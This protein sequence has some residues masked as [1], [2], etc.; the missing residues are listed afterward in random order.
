L[1]ALPE[2]ASKT[3][4][5]VKQEVAA[6]KPDEPKKGFIGLYFIAVF[7]DQTIGFFAAVSTVFFTCSL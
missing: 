5:F 6:P 7:V 4:M 1:T 2:I 3:F